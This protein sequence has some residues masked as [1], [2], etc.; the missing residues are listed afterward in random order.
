MVVAEG[1]VDVVAEEDHDIII[2]LIMAA[3]EAVV[4]EEEEAHPIE[5]GTDTTTPR[6]YT[7]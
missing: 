1:R 2:M 7:K 5:H 4:V 6:H 3:A